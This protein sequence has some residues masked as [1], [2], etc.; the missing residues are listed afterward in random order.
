[1]TIFRHYRSRI[2]SPAL[3]LFLWMLLPVALLAEPEPPKEI[4]GVPTNLGLADLMARRVADEAVAELSPELGESVG[5]KAGKESSGNPLVLLALKEALRRA[6]HGPLDE[7]AKAHRVLEYRVLDLR[8]AYTGVDRGALGLGA[9]VERAGSL[10]LALSLLDG[11]SGEELT[12]IQKEV[13]LA[14]HFP[15]DM[16]ELVSSKAYPFTNPEL[17]E[18]DW[19]KSVEPWV[20]G[21]LVLSLAWLFYSNQSSE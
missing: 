1:M 20:V 19:S 5:V 11:D 21:G 17:K 6:G 4:E 13:M 18:K 9:E 3:A 2:A 10:V 14:D 8:I 7:G 12:S 16:L 15:K